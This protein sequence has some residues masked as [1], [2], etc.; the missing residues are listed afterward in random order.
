MNPQRSQ[1]WKLL[2]LLAILTLTAPAAL[3]QGPTGKIESRLQEALAAQGAAAFIVRFAAQAEL[4]PAAAMGWDERGAFVYRALR[5]TAADSQS[6]AIQELERRHLRYTTWIAGNEL[7]VESGTWPA[8]AALAAL[9]EVRSIR[10]ART[11]YID[12]PLA[13]APAALFQSLPWGLVDTG[14]AAFWASFGFQGDGIVVANIDTGVQWDHPALDQAFRCGADP[15]APACWADPAN[16]CGGSACDN[17]GHGTHTMGT[18]VAGD[19]PTLPYQAGVAP[20]A[21]W[22]ACKG[23][24]S[25]S[26]SEYAL[27]TCADWILAPGGDP[28]NRPHVVN[29]SWGGLGGDAWYL[30]RVAAWRAAGI[31][32]AFSAGNLGASC[33]TLGSPGDYQEAFASA[34]HDASRTIAYFS[35]RGPGTW[36]DPYTKPNLSAPG[37]GICSTVPTDAWDCSYSGTSMASP[38]TAGA[39]ALLWSCNP[40]LVGQVDQTFGILQDSAAAPPPGDCGAAPHGGNYTYGYG[41]LDVYAAG[42]SSCGAA[43]SL[44]GRVTDAGSGSPIGGASVAAARQ[45]G[46]GAFGA[47]SDA[48]GYYTMTVL[49]G[50]YAMTATAYGYEPGVVGGVVVTTATVT[51]RNLALQPL[52]TYVISGTVR[53]Q[54]TGRPLHG[55]VQAVGT[56]VAPAWTDPVTGYYSL[57]LAAGPHTLRAAAI[58]YAALD[59]AVLVDH[60]QT[61]DWELPPLPCILVVDDDQNSPDVRSYYT[62][63]LE[64]LGVPYNLWDTRESG[65]P[66]SDDLLG[67]RIVVWFNG[68]PYAHTFTA[69]DEAAAAA[70]LDAGGSLFLSAE[71]YLW[72]FGLT[73]FGQNYLGVADYT[74]DVR[75][76]DVVGRAGSPIGAGL[77]PYELAAPAGWA[78]VFWTDYVTGTAAPFG[79]QASGADN[80]T[81]AAGAGWRTVFL[82]W[83]LEGIPSADDRTDIML[84]VLS[85]LGGCGEMGQVTGRVTAADSGAPLEGA[86]VTARRT[87]S[88][89]GRD[90][91]TDPAGAYTLTLLPG[92]Y[93]LTARKPYY[94]P[95]VVTGVA[96]TTGTV[97]VDLALEPLEVHTVSLPL[98]NRRYVVVQ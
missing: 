24:E 7:Y 97:V 73:A 72:E 92:T 88:G 66:T 30:P 21:R 89:A 91:V 6:R 58:G 25:S 15:A 85:H 45:S 26:C 11:Y 79:Y 54:D 51:T 82:G 38:H 80:S 4:A 52:P 33:S 5:Q 86:R 43:G 83:P 90:A 57:T 56:P 27:D 78:D 84:A 68:Y 32:P 61:Q 3:A 37:V 18:M 34:A 40:S 13:A 22:I 65:G 98:V 12:P 42:L 8:A 75:E 14:T 59:R 87:A 16:V 1:P 53:A 96:V 41:Y 76:T 64:G 36:P 23:C 10:A 81:S 94:A 39:V 74:V 77:G 48:A 71:D 60:D 29:N 95:A 17:N 19:D 49:A 20:H 28:A 62:A 67:Y 44:T 93:D 9:P 2:A 69:A 55:A 50:T 46:P 70:Y 31:F 63:T 35:S 47:T